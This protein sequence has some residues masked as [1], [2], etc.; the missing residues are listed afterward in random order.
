MKK[1]NAP[2]AMGVEHG[3]GNN[4]RVCDHCGSPTKRFDLKTVKA[5]NGEQEVCIY[6]RRDL[7]I[8]Q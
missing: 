8:F 3:E 5:G 2:R 6:C 1:K 7:G 4:M